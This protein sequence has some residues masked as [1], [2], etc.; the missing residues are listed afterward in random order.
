MK[1]FLIDPNYTDCICGAVY[2]LNY[3]CICPE[4]G[5]YDKSTDYKDNE[6]ER[7]D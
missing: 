5:Y 3:W 2:D 1:E 4:C 6:T 7:K